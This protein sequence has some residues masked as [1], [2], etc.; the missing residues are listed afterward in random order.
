MPDRLSLGGLSDMRYKPFE[1]RRQESD[2]RGKA[3]MEVVD[4]SPRILIVEDEYYLANDLA[5]GLKT[6]GMT[7]VGPVGTPKRPATPGRAA[8]TS[9]CST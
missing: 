6:A 2:R 3:V 9:S 1:G 5:K 8:S 7:I 4:R